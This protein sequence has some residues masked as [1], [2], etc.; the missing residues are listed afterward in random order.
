[1]RKVKLQGNPYEVV[2]Y[3]TSTKDIFHLFRTF[4]L[5]CNI[6]KCMNRY[7][8]VYSQ[9]DQVVVIPGICRTIQDMTLKQWYE[10]AVKN[11]PAG[12]TLVGEQ[13]ILW[14]DLIHKVKH[15]FV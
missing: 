15:S 6:T 11:M 3:P 10:F 9:N 14:E 4:A 12:F 13:G 1:M 5:P 8:L 2:Y 7:D